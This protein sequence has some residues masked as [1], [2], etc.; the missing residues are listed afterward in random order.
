M[1]DER[2]HAAVRAFTQ[3]DIIEPPFPAHVS[4][5]PPGTLLHDHLDQP[6]FRGMDDPRIPRWLVKVMGYSG[7]FERWRVHDCTFL[8]YLTHQQGGHFFAFADGVYEPPV[9]FRAHANDVWLGHTGDMWH[10]IRLVGEWARNPYEMEGKSI[11][12][13]SNMTVN[14]WSMRCLDKQARTW[15]VFDGE[16]MLASFAWDELRVAAQLRYRVFGSVEEHELYASHAGET[17]AGQSAGARL[18]GPRPR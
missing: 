9:L 2:I 6:N 3:K 7:L 12:M 17:Q 10:G 4:I 16:R 18:R 8:L 1:E 14:P 5:L 11:R 15:G 13:L